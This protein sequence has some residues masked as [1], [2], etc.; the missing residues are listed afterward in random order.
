M[1][2]TLRLCV[3]PFS[4]LLILF[5]FGFCRNAKNISNI[6]L[7]STD[8]SV[9]TSTGQVGRKMVVSLLTILK[10]KGEEGERPEEK[11]QKL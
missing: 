6:L 2:L 1:F 3:L 11:K 10:S 8:T 4:L 9:S 7:S 5:L